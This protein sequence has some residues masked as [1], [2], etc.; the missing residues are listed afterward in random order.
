[1]TI[2]GDPTQSLREPRY[3]RGTK[4]SRSGGLSRS[5]R[6]PRPYWPRNDIFSFDFIKEESAPALCLIRVRGAI[7]SVKSVESVVKPFALFAKFAVPFFTILR[8]S[9]YQIPW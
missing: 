2:R 3:K 7:Q 8:N 6:L 4:Q 1:M 5:R 9:P